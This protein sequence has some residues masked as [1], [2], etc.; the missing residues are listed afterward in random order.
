[1]A[2]HYDPQDPS[3]SQD[4]SSTTFTDDPA[5]T[6]PPKGPFDAYPTTPE[7]AFSGPPFKRLA[8]RLKGYQPTREEMDSITRA[9]GKVVQYAAFATTAG[10]GMGWFF[11]T[12]RRWRVLPRLATAAASGMIGLWLGLGF[13]VRAG[14][15]TMWNVP[16][17]RI[18]AEIEQIIREE[19]RSPWRKD[20]S[21]STQYDQ[22]HQHHD[23]QPPSSTSQSTTGSQG[24][25]QSNPARYE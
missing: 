19:R 21:S 5:G 13:G 1:M 15:Q 2:I 3:S 9:S 8:A 16:E 20:G 11:G 23:W 22:H 25:E 12:K 24:V 10:A 18:V 17:S 7:D 4:P 14:L 6:Q